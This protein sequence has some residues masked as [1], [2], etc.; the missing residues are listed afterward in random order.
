MLVSAAS[1]A[2]VD[3]L[4][5]R[6]VQEGIKVIRIGHPARC[7]EGMIGHSLSQKV[8]K[9]RDALEETKME[10]ERI[11]DDIHRGKHK[12]KPELKTELKS[13]QKKR[14]KEKLT[15]DKLSKGH[16][17]EASVV[18][19]TL[20]GCRKKGPL[21]LPPDDFFKTTV[22]DECGQ[23]LEMACWIVI[24]RAPRL[25]LAGDHHQLPPTVITKNQ[26][27]AKKLSVSLME[28]LRERFFY[29]KN[30]VFHM[31]KVGMTWC[32]FND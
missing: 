13:L 28:R 18:L 17:L 21:R 9:E 7:S 12:R 15:V 14:D 26:E 31:L 3:N 24:P 23:S 20:I 19:G 4:G 8:L 25:I 6:L 2:A 10:I 30:A 22:I 11:Q 16:L 5:E 1:N 27:A 32:I 29:G